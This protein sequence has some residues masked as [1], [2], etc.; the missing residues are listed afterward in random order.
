[1]LLG[2]K[3]MLIRSINTNIL[4]MNMCIYMSILA[5]IHE[6]LNTDSHIY[7]TSMHSVDKNS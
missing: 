1:M 2:F 3:G 5:Y 4:F 7:H 6:F